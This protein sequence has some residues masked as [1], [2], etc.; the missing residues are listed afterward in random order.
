MCLGVL[1]RTMSA[2]IVIYLTTLFITYTL[3]HFQIFNKHFKCSS[4][5]TLTGYDN[6]MFV[7]R[8]DR[9]QRMKKRTYGVKSA[10]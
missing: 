7:R 8:N 1:F 2:L 10:V 6:I 9:K 4:V 3:L 5:F